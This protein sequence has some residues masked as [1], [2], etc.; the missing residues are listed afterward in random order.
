MSH[1]SVWSRIFSVKLRCRRPSCHVSPPLGHVSRGGLST[2]ATPISIVNRYNSVT[3]RAIAMRTV[4][5]SVISSSI[6]PPSRRRPSTGRAKFEVEQFKIYKAVW[7]RYAQFW[8]FLSS[9][10]DSTLSKARTRC[11]ESSVR[12]LGPHF[13]T[14]GTREI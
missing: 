11:L 10:L 13:Q 4:V 7:S 14:C 3:T 9:R 8:T 5:L 12:P 6:R 2:S 1:I